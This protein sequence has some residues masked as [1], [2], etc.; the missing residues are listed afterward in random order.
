[1]ASHEFYYN[2][3]ALHELGQVTLM[4]QRT[5]YTPDDAPQRER[6]DLTVRVNFFEA[7]FADN[8]AL[9]S[10]LRTLLRTTN[11]VF[12]WKNEHGKDVL[13]RSVTVV[14]HNLPED[15][16][17]NGRRM[18]S[19]QFECFYIR[20]DLTGN[21]MSGTLTVGDATSSLGK[22]TDWQETLTSE[23]QNNLRPHRQRTAIAV[24]ARGFI[25]GDTTLALDARRTAML[26]L[27]NTLLE[28]CNKKEGRLVYGGFD[29]VVRVSEFTAE[30]NQA[31]NHIE[32]TL[33][34][35]CTLFPD[36]Q[37][38]ALADY[39][40]MIRDEGA[41]KVLVVTGKVMAHTQAAATNRITQILNAAVPANGF[42]L[43]REVRREEVPTTLEADADGSAF[44]GMT[45][46]R[47]FR[48]PLANTLS[49]TR[50]GGEAVS[51]GDVTGWRET[52]AHE[53]FG[54]MKNKI[55][56]T[57]IRVSARGVHYVDT[58]NSLEVR[59]Q[60]LQAA[61][62]AMQ[63]E[64]NRGKV[65]L[66]H[67]DFEREVRPLDLN[68][69]I[70]ATARF[71]T[72]EMG[73]EFTLAPDETDYAIAEYRIRERNGGADKL[74]SLT[75]RIQANS[76]SKARTRLAQ[77]RSTVLLARTYSGGLV[78]SEEDEVT[79]GSSTE[80]DEFVDLTFS[81]DFR[82]PLPHTLAWTPLN[83][84]T[85]TLGQITGWSESLTNERFAKHKAERRSALVT[86]QVTG[87]YFADATQTL[88]VRRA[89]LQAKKDAWLAA[90]G[91]K[92]GRLVNGN[93]DR[94][95]RCNEFRPEIDHAH[96]VLTWTMNAEYARFPDEAN[97]TTV[98][99]RLSERDDGADKLLTLRGRIE[100]N[101]EAKARTRFDELKTALLQARGYESSRAVQE[102]L[103]PSFGV[104]DGEVTTFLELTFT[105]EY[106]LQLDNEAK[107]TPE[108]GTVADR[109]ILG[110]VTGMSY[111]YQSERYSKLRKNR[112]HAGGVI[113][114]SGV[115]LADTTQPLEVRRETLINLQ[116]AWIA[117]VNHAQGTI[118]HGTLTQVV[119]VANFDAQIDH[120]VRGLNWSM[121]GEFSLFPNE[122][123]YALVEYSVT[124]RKEKETGQTV[125][126]FNGRIGAQTKAAAEAK[127]ATLRTAV[128]GSNSDYVL[129][130]SEATP[131]QVEAA[132][133]GAAFLEL[134][135]SEEYVVGEGDIVRWRVSI[136]TREELG[137]GMRR[138]T[139]SGTVTARGADFEAAKT[140]AFTKA[141]VLGDEKS[142]FK[143]DEE[144][145]VEDQL[146]TTGGERLV[147]VQF[148]FDY[149]ARTSR[150]HLEFTS[151]TSLD[152]F[153]EN[154]DS[155][156]GFV[157]AETVAA[158]QSAYTAS[159]KAAFAGKLIKSERTSVRKEMLQKLDGETL[160][161]GEYEEQ[162]QRL[163][164]SFSAHREKAVNE[165]AMKYELTVRDDD[166]R[167]KRTY[168]ISGSVVAPGT[169]TAA[170]GG[171]LRANGK[172]T[173]GEKAIHDFLAG[174]A[175][176]LGTRQGLEIKEEKERF[177][178]NPA[179][180]AG[181]IE[182]SI[183]TT[184]TGT[185]ERVMSAENKV[186]Y[187]RI[188]IRNRH[189]G[190]RWVA[191]GIP[192]GRSIMQDCGIVEGK[193]VVTGE[194]V[195]ITEAA[196]DTWI[197]QQHAHITGPYED[198]PEIASDYDFI[199]GLAGVVAGDGKNWAL[200]A[201][202]FT[203]A[204]T[205]PDFDYAGA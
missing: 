117:K 192:D 66:K 148:S 154:T 143:L 159:V 145:T 31:V 63:T 1:M 17:A 50:P 104:G 80:G 4:E 107:F 61:K 67:G 42:S 59:K 85:V 62:S 184:F 39:Q 73:F 168:M 123:G 79:W 13:N 136:R 190:K 126:V 109:I 32:W 57:I 84:Q 187:C 130:R 27:K 105:C 95:V 150:L 74:L 174:M 165:V 46:M 71:L 108:G 76:E 54:P 142:P 137:A 14:R 93:F 28:R 172:M 90:F 53:R 138:L 118:E 51:F 102:E 116:K 6:V 65:T 135:F 82:K 146:T 8:H 151:E 203:F 161:E 101:D 45:F 147:T 132:S 164:F 3:T 89:A 96:K 186:L 178:G 185:Y 198:P 162:F 149:R 69:D 43:Q 78:E 22:I 156:S 175:A 166:N 24:R 127:L 33:A 163:D 36:E 155:A 7:S 81:Q 171:V 124:S 121:T 5:A 49:L 181:V 75:G 26:A 47:E 100:A 86:V 40:V 56:R 21:V 99:Y 113:R 19:L 200:V 167:N 88:E 169:Q 182:K 202:S 9:V 131:N 197:S 92:N 64:F 16:N 199:P 188:S 37:N 10:T 204:E 122:A 91:A 152:T 189:S 58:G 158:A 48:L 94:I 134:S 112:S 114:L 30:V 103:E 179:T 115:H 110:K 111:L 83:G 77:I 44:N 97:F 176:M 68:A 41:D 139:Y 170:N 38:Y 70:E 194:V 23:R 120:A 29:R 144:L 205:L 177:I 125:L 34:A 12:Q 119:R 160:V 133:D 157:V 141:R 25:A 60:Q 183:R 15:P 129:L 72:W 140:A 195:A 55:M 191:Q 128:L 196:A 173:V 87:Q 18:Q 98:E 153:G 11:A 52:L 193:R 106:R 2:G 35:D 20:H 201:K 180:P